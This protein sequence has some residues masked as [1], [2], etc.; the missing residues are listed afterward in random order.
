MSPRRRR[1]QATRSTRPHA[2]GDRRPARSG[3]LA[4]LFL[5]PFA[6]VVFVFFV[7]PVVLT[8]LM[9]LT[10]VSVATGLG[11]FRWIGLD[12]YRRILGDPSAGLVLRNTF[13]Y[14]GTTLVLFNVGLALVLALATSLVPERWGGLFR[15]VWLLPRITPSVVYVLVWKYMAAEPP[16]GVINQALGWLGI[17]ST[18]NWLYAK[19]WAMVI[20]I[21]GLV[22]ASMGMIIFSAAIRAIPREQLVAAHVD[23]AGSWSLIRHIVLP[24]LRWPA[25]FVAAYQTLSLLASYEYIL[26]ATNGGPGYDTTEVWALYAFHT[27][28]S[29]YFGNAQFG[30][31]AA[32]A[33]V[34]VLIGVAAS[35]LYLRFF[36][37]RTM[38]GGPRIEAA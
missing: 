14:V 23:G 36:N 19:P 37:F 16:Y 35:V 13:F 7:V 20:A 4:L 25:L 21:N 6:L 10:D 2:G 11:G 1:G 26:L 12:N 17:D 28:L 9:S 8:L 34:L 3:R 22:G 29:N 5:L 15:A 24:Q 33:T 27:A 18:Q 38:T 31:G 30:L 32:L